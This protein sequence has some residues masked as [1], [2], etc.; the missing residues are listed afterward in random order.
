MNSRR[1]SQTALGTAIGRALESGMPAEKRLFSDPL[2]V[3]F[4]PWF[5]RAIVRLLQTPAI[6]ELLL[7]KREKEIP[8]VMGNLI[9]R[10]RFIDDTLQD[11]LARGIRQVVILGAGMDSRPYRLPGNEGTRFFEVDH[12]ATLE[13]KR[14]RV[15]KLK[16]GIPANT[17]FVP[18]DFTKDDLASGLFYT[19]FR[20]DQRT[21]FIWEGVSQYIGADAVDSTLKYI[22]R[23]SAPGSRLVFTYIRRDFI[24]DCGDSEE[25]RKFLEELR[26]KDEPWKFG[27]APEFLDRF[28]RERGFRL[29]SDTGAADYRGLYLE[30]TGRDMDLFEGERV[31]VAEV[32]EA[33]AL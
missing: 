20:T 6:G 5:H 26:K 24:E 19:G 13:W 23:V 9:C 3:R 7:E 32:Q 16:G 2:A 18:I 29:V 8:G 25:F 30:K 31:A 21:L 28:L 15:R 14:I 33:S 1:P 10:T 27:I 22:K 17:E 12:P 11:A 4:L